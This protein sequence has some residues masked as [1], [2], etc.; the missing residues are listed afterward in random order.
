MSVESD[1]LQEILEQLKSGSGS[2][3]GTPTRRS[4]TLRGGAASGELGDL[5]ARKEHLDDLN[6]QEELRLKLLDRLTNAQTAYNAAVARSADPAEMARVSA[7]LKEA[8]EN[9]EDLNKGV[10]DFGAGTQAFESMADSVLGLSG[11]MESL[12]QVINGGRNSML[13]FGTAM[14]EGVWNTLHWHGTEDGRFLSRICF[15][16]RRSASQL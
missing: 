3:S 12:S 4:S 8:G 7:A 1:L 14:L 6:K 10:K 15:A 5:Q 16:H 13:G 11:P 9:L 2:S